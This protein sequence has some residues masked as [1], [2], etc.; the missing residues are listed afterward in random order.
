[1]LDASSD[2]AIVSMA[3]NAGMPEPGP[4]RVLRRSVE[5]AEALES[6][7]AGVIRLAGAELTVPRFSPLPPTRSSTGAIGAM[8]FYAGQSAGAVQRDQPAADIVAELTRGVSARSQEAPRSRARR[9]FSAARLRYCRPHIPDRETDRRREQPQPGRRLAGAPQLRT[10]SSRCIGNRAV[11]Q[12]LARAPVRTGSIQ[13]GA[14]GE[15][16]VRGRNLDEW[17]GKG[18]PDTVE[19]TSKKG[20]AF[21]Q[22]R[23]DVERTHQGGREGDDRACQQGRRGAR[24][25]GRGPLLEIKDVR[26]GKA[27]AIEAGVETWR[28]AD[29]EN[30]KRTKVTHKIA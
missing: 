4:H 18:A 29:F 8:P 22:A 12:V 9:W 10:R 28:V 19:V 20:Q 21:R 13:I 6:D 30:V 5:A 11:V 3:F 2:E 27:F 7:G 15:I 24:R 1:M 23:E 14:V 16:K 25:G 17:A 26:S